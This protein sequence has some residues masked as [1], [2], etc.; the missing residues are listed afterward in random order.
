MKKLIQL[1]SKKYKQNIGH[2]KNVVMDSRE[3]GEDSL[4]FAINNGN[5][6]VD[7]AIKNGASL[8]IADNYM[9]ENEK[10]I[11][12]KDTVK[13]MQEIAKLYIKELDI[14]VIAITGSNGKTTTKDIVANILATEY[15]VCKT[16]GNYNNHI[17]VP[18]TILQAKDATQI[19]V[20]EM[21]M[22]SFGEIDL[23]CQIA[24]PDYGIITNIGDSH[25]EFLKTRQNVAKA[26]LEMAKYIKPQNLIVCG[27]DVFLKDV[28][29]N[30]VG[31]N[32]N[33]DFI[34][35]D[36]QL[37]EENSKFIIDDIH[38]KTPLCGKH[39][40]YNSAFA[41]ILTKKLGIKDIKFD[42]LKI[43]DGRFQK[44]E[45]GNTIFIN[46]AYNASPISMRYAIDTFSNMH[47]DINKIAVLG[48]MLELGD[49]EINYH[50]EILEYLQDKNIDNIYLYG[51]RMKKALSQL[52]GDSKRIKYYQN[53]DD[54]K[55]EILKIKRKKAVLLKGSRGMRLEEIM[56]EICYI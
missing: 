11:K 44:I 30:K 39:N 53:K 12:V 32:E 19:L 43:T 29:G 50:R 38:I 15:K 8:V 13:E 1:L 5:R 10:V 45:N 55:K 2:I 9:G 18:F 24:R 35:K 41:T 37:K 54:I 36:M 17:G 21:G 28:K 16:Q 47:S 23:L 42:N 33:N 25:L 3:V 4:F 48:D 7:N 46:D 56:G 6:F 27:D 34:I 14:P 40:V 49:N 26:K 31:F 51:E 20:L 22:S 52:K